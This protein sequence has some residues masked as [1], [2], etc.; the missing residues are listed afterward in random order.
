MFK[1]KMNRLTEGGGQNNDENL[2]TI[3]NALNDGWIYRRDEQNNDAKS[4]T[5]SDGKGL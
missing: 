5:N 1:N 4:V 3:C 2:T